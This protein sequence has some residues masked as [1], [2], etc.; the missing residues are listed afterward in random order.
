MRTE[1]QQ[2]IV[3]GVLAAVGLA[4]GVGVWWPAHQQRQQYHQHIE[5]ARQT[6]KKARQSP[7]LE[8]WHQAVD[9]LEQRLKGA[10]QHVPTRD[11]PAEVLRGL[12][13]ALR[14]HGVVDQE[15]I[16]R[17]A[18]KYGEHRVIRIKVTF[19]GSF[20]A[21]YSIVR[22]IEQMP[23]LIQIDR[24]AITD[25]AGQE[26]GRLAVDLELSTFFSRMKEGDH[27]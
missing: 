18:R 7:K 9:Q 3:F 6:L 5:Q 23:R 2:F 11:K 15:V 14:E 27:G 1:K 26:A 22:R 4:F 24:F 13:R 20:P 16:T 17:P 21:A 25:A 10:Q 8:T 12:A 19:R